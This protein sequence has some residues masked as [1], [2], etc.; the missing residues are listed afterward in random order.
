[1]SILTTC[2]LLLALVIDVSNSVDP[3]E[4]EQQVVGTAEALMADEVG[5]IVKNMDGGMAVTVI[6]F[7]DTA[8]VAIDWRV[9]R[10]DEE[11]VSLARDIARMDRMPGLYTSISAGLELAIQQMGRPPCEGMRMT[12][13]V[14]AD[15]VNNTGRTTRD[16][17]DIAQGAGIQ[18]NGLAVL[19]DNPS[20]YTSNE[21]LI[22]FIQD[23]VITDGGYTSDGNYVF[24]GFVIEANGYEEYGRAIL[25][26]LQREI[27]EGMERS[28]GSLR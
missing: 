20:Y 18:I 10:N 1:M 22:R 25:R 15:G 17:R 4:Y 23:N 11:R 5:R 27:S 28:Y 6:Q 8:S 24:P 13:D 14:S 21:N 16:V 7:A 3:K 9:I 26:K 2:A 12:I 19:D